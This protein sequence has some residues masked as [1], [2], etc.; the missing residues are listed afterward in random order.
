MVVN[1]SQT[2][3]ALYDILWLSNEYISHAFSKVFCASSTPIS[4]FTDSPTAGAVD[5]TAVLSGVAVSFL[6]LALLIAGI[7]VGLVLLRRAKRKRR[8]LKTRTPSIESMECTKVLEEPQGTEESPAGNRCEHCIDDVRVEQYVEEL[9]HESANVLRK[10]S[11]DRVEGNRIRYNVDYDEIDAAEILSRDWDR[12]STVEE[13]LQV[14]QP[15][16]TPDAVYAVVDK[17]RK[18]KKGE[19]EGDQ[20]TI[21][22]QDPYTEEQHYESST[23]IGMDWLG[24]E[25]KPEGDASGVEMG[26]PSGDP[27]VT[28]LQSESCEPNAVYAVVDK[29]KK[30]KKGKTEGDQSTTATQDPYTEVQHY[31]SSTVL[32]MDWVQN[33]VNSNEDVGETKKGSSSDDLKVTGLSV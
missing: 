26:S 31:E 23:V 5:L 22:T 19:S 24:T 27:K 29:S 33:E 2:R 1:E 17:S 3:V 9:N 20:S 13:G 4:F 7:I 18:K 14:D 28:G 6:L 16:D 15:T 21:A 32:G 11:L 10:R 25:M 8:S 12:H 30:K